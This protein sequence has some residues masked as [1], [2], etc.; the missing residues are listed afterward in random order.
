M[1]Q[2]AQ[3][4]AEAKDTANRANTTGRSSETTKDA[5]RKKKRV[6]LLALLV[7]LVL[8][9]LWLFLRKPSKPASA[10]ASGLTER[11]DVLLAWVP[12]P[13]ADAE[14]LDVLRSAASQLYGDITGASAENRMALLTPSGSTWQT[15]SLP[16]ADTLS[17]ALLSED[18]AGTGALDAALRSAKDWNGVRE[19]AEGSVILLQKLHGFLQGGDQGGHFLVFL[20][21]TVHQLSRALL[22]ALI[23]GCMRVDFLQI[24]L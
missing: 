7:F 16:D 20:L 5:G 11:R 1:K 21:N 9:L 6:L 12:S 24:L 3:R 15:V 2:A 10:D 4:S 18:G 8:L 19:G 14:S 23:P 13:E 22:K 17:A